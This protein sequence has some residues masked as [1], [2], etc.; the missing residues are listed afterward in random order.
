M[1]DRSEVVVHLVLG[2]EGRYVVDAVLR[3]LFHVLADHIIHR[4]LSDAGQVGH[5]RGVVEQ[6][7]IHYSTKGHADVVGKIQRYKISL[8]KICQPGRVWKPTLLEDLTDPRNG[9]RIGR[10]GRVKAISR[11]VAAVWPRGAYPW[12]PRGLWRL[13]ATEG[14]PWGRPWRV[15]RTLLRSSALRRSAGKS[16]SLLL[17]CLPRNLCNSNSHP[18]C[19]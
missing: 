14:G 17:L 3:F 5:L 10:S 8:W 4:F 15:P 7:S 12:M 16:A 13:P 11:R 9:G 19:C 1:I 6:S 2:D 18:R